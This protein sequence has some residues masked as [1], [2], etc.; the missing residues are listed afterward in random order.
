MVNW[1][2]PVWRDFCWEEGSNAEKWHRK[3]D[4]FINDSVG[5]SIC[6]CP[7]ETIKYIWVNI[8]WILDWVLPQNCRNTLPLHTTVKQLGLQKLKTLLCPTNCLQPTPTSLLTRWKNIKIQIWLWFF[9][10]LNTFQY[11]NYVAFSL[12]YVLL[13]QGKSQNKCLLFSFIS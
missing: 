12:F 11:K 9:H 5:L 4:F 13:R 3:K 8:W 6:D 7:V 1:H 2:A 10:C